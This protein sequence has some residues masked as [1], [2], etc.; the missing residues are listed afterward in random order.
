MK[1]T[2]IYRLALSVLRPTLPV[3]LGLALAVCCIGI[4]SG[5]ALPARSG[6]VRICDE[7]SLRLA[8]EGG[9]LVTFACDGVITL[10][11]PL[12]IAADSRIDGA[13]HAVT[14][15]GNNA[16]RLFLVRNGN[17]TLRNLTIAN[18]LAQGSACGLGGGGGGAGLG[19]GIFIDGGAVTITQ[20][21]FSGNTARGG[22]GCA[23]TSSSG[24]AAPGSA[25]GSG[26][27]AGLPADGGGNGGAGGAVNTAGATG[28][29]G[30]FGGGGGGGAMAAAARP[31]AR[32]V[33]AVMAERAALAAAAAAAAQAAGTSAWAATVAGLAGAA[34][35]AAVVLALR[36]AAAAAAGWGQ[37]GRCLSAA[38]A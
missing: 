25:G 20:V 8:V 3:L 17:L 38:A 22:S 11:Q 5:R 30:G 18:G 9:G 33:G 16:T 12:V 37:A 13:G 35:M 36:M 2:A 6:L 23:P 7:S 29:L 14:L 31:R 27:G 4:A 34:G 24:V 28:G 19:G 32:V 10:S 15:S 1:T 21:T 26:G